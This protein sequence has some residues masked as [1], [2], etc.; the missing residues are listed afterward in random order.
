MLSYQGLTPDEAKL[1][2]GGNATAAVSA[3]AL[4]AGA[5]ALD[6]P[7][8]QHIGG[9][10]A[11][12]LPGRRLPATSAAATATTAGLPA[13]QQAE[14]RVRLLRLR[15][16][17][18]GLLRRLGPPHRVRRR[19]C[20][21]KFGIAKDCDARRQRRADRRRACSRATARSGTW[22]S[23]RS[24]GSA[25]RA[26]SACRSTAPRP[27]TT[28][29]TA[30]TT[31]ASSSRASKTRD[32]MIR[33]YAEMVE[34]YP[35]VILEDPLDEDDYEGHAILTRELGI[36]ITGDDLFTTNPARVQKGIEVGAGEQRAAEGEPDRH[37]LRG[38]RDGPARLP[39]RLRRPAVLE[40]RRGRGHR[41]LHRR[42]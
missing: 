13:G 19:R 21:K 38:V 6:I 11:V 41:R 3:A 26:R 35:F 20:S 31:R 9:A 18:R 39:Q 36:Q 25:T 32:Q 24:P 29:G 23:R 33:M 2:L 27:A 22:P 28:T 15:H 10:N 8:Y 40:P 42:A 12:V 5:A 4:K 34:N 1:K 37:D 30:T 16:L 14:P 7:L 17:R